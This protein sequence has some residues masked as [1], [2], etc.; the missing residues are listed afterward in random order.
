MKKIIVA[1]PLLLSGLT[2]QAE[3][4]K[5]VDADGHV[6]YSNMP[7]KGATRLNLEPLPPA[8]PS[9]S[10]KPRSPGTS[11]PAGFPKVDQETQKQRDSKRQE[12]LNNE[13]E[14][15]RQALEEAKKNLT[16]GQE[17]PEVYRGKDGKTYRNVNKYDE[18]IEKLQEDV[19]LHQKNIELLEKELGGPS[20]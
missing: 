15:E 17:A 11:S 9:S 14:S 5:H 8:N 20:Q 7:M 16:E 3:I 18:K 1:L 6:T 13:L 2:V 19:T 12:I 10:S 4:Y